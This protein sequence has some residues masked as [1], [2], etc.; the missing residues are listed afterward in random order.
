MK[1][2]INF[3]TLAASLVFLMTLMSCSKETE[4]PVS[5][6]D[7]G[8]LEGEW[9]CTWSKGISNLEIAENA[10]VGTKW[11]FGAPA[12][13]AND[14]THQLGEFRATMNGIYPEGI[15]GEYHFYD[16][17]S[18]RLPQ[19]AVWISEYNEFYIFQ[20]FH[21]FKPGDAYRTEGHYS[22]VLTDDALTLYRYNED[23]DDLSNDN[24]YLKFRKNR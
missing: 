5:S 13:A 24:L 20:G 21:E 15:F 10:Y 14:D 9:E 1:K 3:L 23:S 19:L 12:Q 11:T 4:T 6:R 2:K 17:D 7:A 22:I 16:T 8:K 18:S